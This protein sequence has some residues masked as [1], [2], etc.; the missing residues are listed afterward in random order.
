M[1]DFAKYREIP[2]AAK[3]IIIKA[4]I[5]NIN[6]LSFS[7]KIFFI[8]GSNNQAIADVLAATKIE[9]KAAKNIFFKNFF[10]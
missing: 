9:K 7:R 2:L 6:V 8:A 5:T 4:G 3:V 10:E 1:V